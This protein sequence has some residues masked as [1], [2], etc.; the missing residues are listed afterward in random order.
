MLLG[1][2]LTNH[3]R[4]KKKKNKNQTIF[5]HLNANLYCARNKSSRIKK[6]KMVDT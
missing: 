1:F 4:K 2:K 3:S 6:K 5:K